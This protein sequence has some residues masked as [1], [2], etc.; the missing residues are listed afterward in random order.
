VVV[1]SPQPQ[2][3]YT[4][5]G[6]SGGNAPA[7]GDIYRGLDLFGR[8]K[9][10]I[11][12]GSGSSS[13]SSSSSSGSSGASG[14]LEEIQHGYD[15][16]GN[17]VYRADPVDPNDRHDEF[18]DYDGLYR[19]KDLTR[20]GLNAGKTGIATPTFAQCW[21][22]DATGN[23]AN[24]QQ[25]NA[26]SGPWS[27]VQNR[28][29]NATNEI[30]AIATPAGAQ[31]AIPAYDA[32]GNMTTMPQPGAPTS[33]YSV[34]YDAWNR[35]I[36]L[37]AN[38][39]VVAQYQYDGRTRRTVK[40]KYTG[41]VVTETRDFYYSGSWQVLEERV[42]PS[43]KANRQFVWGLRYL[44]ELVLRD[45]DTIGSGTLN[46]RFYA[47]QDPNWNVTAILDAAG[48][49]QERCAYDA[50]G[51]PGVLTPTFA[52]RSSSLFD[53]ELLYAGYRSDSESQLC[54]VRY[55]QYHPALG[56]WLQRDPVAG[57]VNSYRY[58]YN[59]TTRS[60]DPVGLLSMVSLVLPP[61]VWPKKA[62]KRVEGCCGA[63]ITQALLK[64][65]ANLAV[66][67][68]DLKRVK[69]IE[70]CDLMYDAFT[71]WDIWELFNV[72][73]DPA[74]QKNLEA[75][76]CSTGSCRDRV[77]VDGAC[78]F[79]GH[80]NYYLWG[81]MNRLCN[82]FFQTNPLADAKWEY[83]FDAHD[84][85][86]YLDGERVPPGTGRTYSL[87]AA[88][89]AMIEYRAVRF[90]VVNSLGMYNNPGVSE[91]KAWIEAGWY[92]DL[93][94]AKSAAD[95]LCNPCGAKYAG[96]LSGRVGLKNGRYD[97]RPWGNAVFYAGGWG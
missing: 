49:I 30:T 90:A 68:A 5:V 10:L 15:R 1:N 37:I 84:R 97:Y 78:H 3:Q 96:I 52:P 54:Q 27:L 33:S 58:T 6:I 21:S 67:F 16:A 19:L 11:W 2:V 64:L 72:D 93:G 80:A 13:S 82:D 57:D 94:R 66:K 53:W 42:A 62:P 9:D 50:Y 65:G 63:D 55:R 46:E 85:Y 40:K 12:T 75:P 32:A 51:L 31:W 35:L 29:S 73:H 59:R 88:I 45:R 20:G 91:R 4:L 8:V 14:I 23:W 71:G 76:G 70:V 86:L 60:T 92:N 81:R 56:C 77:T 83:D 43:T 95:P 7:T 61:A 22:L 87:Q 48:K 28:T 26:G 18:Y 25:N 47:L 34:T 24:F 79:A 39:I 36:Q 44:D 38:G 74:K 17:R 41:G 69:K 89:D